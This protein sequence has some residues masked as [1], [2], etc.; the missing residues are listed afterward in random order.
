MK[1]IRSLHTK[2]HRDETGLYLVEGEKMVNE[3]LTHHADSIELLL[4]TPDF[5]IKASFPFEIIPVSDKLLADVSALTTPNKALAVLR[6]GNNHS[7]SIT[8]QLIIALDGV[9]DPG[10]MGTILRIADWFGI[11]TVLCSTHT[12]ECYNPKV[13]QASMGAIFRVNTRYTDLAAFMRTY[14]EPIFG[15][16]LDGKNIYG[17]QLPAKGMLLM[18]NEGNG[19]S[20]E[21][22]P[23]ITHPL[24]IPRFG[25]AESL[26]VSVATGIILSEFK[27]AIHLR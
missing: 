17:E 22:L 27:R 26:N 23:F 25:G 1:W 16:V 7:V 9:Q 8:D 3:A 2:K 5:L 24:S 4:H 6:K 10:N 13:I 15:A 12:V 19:I 11:H 14:T 20:P 21:L 18:G